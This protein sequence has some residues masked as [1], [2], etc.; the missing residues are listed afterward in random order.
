MIKYVIKLWI[1][2]ILCSAAL[3]FGNAAYQAFEKIDKKESISRKD[4]TEESHG[5]NEAPAEDDI[6]LDN[7]ENRW[8]EISDAQLPAELTGNEKYYQSC[9][10]GTAEYA[11]LDAA[12][13]ALYEKGWSEKQLLEAYPLLSPTGKLFLKR[14]EGDELWKA[15]LLELEC[16]L[17]YLEEMNPGIAFEDE[18]HGMLLFG[19]W[20]TVLLVT[21]D[22][23]ETWELTESVPEPG[24]VSHNRADCITNCGK[25]RYLIG[26]RYWTE[27]RGS[28]WLTRDNGR[29]WEKVTIAIPETE[30]TFCYVEPVEFSY[31][32]EIVSLTV[33]MHVEDETGQ[34]SVIYYETISQDEGETWSVNEPDGY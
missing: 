5:K 20:Y 15:R 10:A 25:N 13:Y 11:V 18:E 14:Q 27:P 32:G 24:S 4:E 1:L 28:I 17:P 30:E 9:Q 19:W 12:T 33:C 29:S 23:G 3:F 2:G 34:R 26:Y 16:L 21:Q 7:A 31:D 8:F 6:P 22:G